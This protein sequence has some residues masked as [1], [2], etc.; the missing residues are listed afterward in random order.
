MDHIIRYLVIMMQFTSLTLNRPILATGSL[1]AYF[2]YLMTYLFVSKIS[3]L[4]LE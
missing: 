2:P 4:S 1:A 3:Y